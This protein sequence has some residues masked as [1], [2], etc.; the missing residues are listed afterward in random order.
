MRLAVAVGTVST[1]SVGA[2]RFDRRDLGGLLPA[3]G[4]QELAAVQSGG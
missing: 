3:V 1:L 2:G 4:V